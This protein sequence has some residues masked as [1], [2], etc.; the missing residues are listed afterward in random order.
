MPTFPP[1]IFDEPR[2]TQLAELPH[3][4][5][6]T[7]SRPLASQQQALSHETPFTEA[8]AAHSNAK[9]KHRAYQPCDQ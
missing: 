1:D 4:R 9:P 6:H 8:A 3:G 7:L 2:A 5:V